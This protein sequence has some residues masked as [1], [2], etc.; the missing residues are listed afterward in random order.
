MRKTR[1]LLII[2]CFCLLLP[3][4]ACKKEE[5]PNDVPD[6]KYYYDDSSRERAADSIPLE[7]DLENQTITF[8]M[9]YPEFKDVVGDSESTDI[10]YSKIYERNLSVIERL[11]VDLQFAATSSADMVPELKKEISTMSTAWE[12]VFP[13]SAQAVGNKLF[14]Y[15]HNLNDS[16]YI[17]ISERWWQEDAIMELSMDNYNYR[18][19][20]GDINISD[21]HRAGCIFYNKPLY[22]QYVSPTKDRDDLYQTVIDGNWTLE[23]FDRLVRKCHIERG[24]DGSNDIYGLVKFN[25][26]IVH[27]MRESSGIR[28]YER[29]AQGMPEFNF[30]ND[31]SISFLNKLNR[32]IYEN[33]GT[34]IHSDAG[35]A[36]LDF[37][38]GK[39]VFETSALYM[40]F[41]NSFREMKDD[42]GIIPYPK[43]DE[44]QEEYITMVHNA[45]YAVCI[46]VS[47]DIDRANE[48]ISAV[49]EA[50]ASESYRNVS[51]SF[52]E[53]ALKAAYNRDDQSAQ[54][55]DIICGQHDT[56]KSTVSRNFAFEYN[57][58][59]NGISNIF[60]TLMKNNSGDFVSSYDS[61]IGSAES[62]LKELIK[63]Y[64]DGKL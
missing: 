28:T 42:F 23:E 35:D 44:N 12:A 53:M 5:K 41:N 50:L 39:L 25:S 1:F 56:I 15:F 34:N 19:L 20:F 38:N 11:N 8:L 52:Y 48:E 26:A 55:I 17:D 22:E 62:G 24:G 32:M 49:I 60:Y 3:I 29:N 51:V 59:L 40:V 10:L 18:F 9:R 43:F 61:I 2:L 36:N 37:E 57:S 45:S 21:T 27:F 46:P 6:D 7:Y 64:K 31:H 47:T 30:K 63:Q 54:M 13:T 58:S 4:V 16:N 14:N 33:P